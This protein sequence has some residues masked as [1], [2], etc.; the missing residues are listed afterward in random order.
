MVDQYGQINLKGVYMPSA[1]HMSQALYV[2]NKGGINAATIPER[3]LTPQPIDYNNIPSC[4]YCT[5]EIASVGYTESS[6]DAGYEIKV[7]R[8]FPFRSPAA[9]L[10][11][12]ATRRF[13]KSDPT[14][15][16]EVH[17]DAMIGMNA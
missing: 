13:C 4:T 1:V 5:P 14:P 9:R 15:Y 11:A 7:V 2:A 8:K 6:Q 10:A 12:G 3:T 17:S 16:G